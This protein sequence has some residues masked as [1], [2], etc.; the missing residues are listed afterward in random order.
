MKFGKYG[1]FTFTDILDAKQL[2][3]LPRRLEELGY[4][5]LWYPEA[6]NYE[7]FAV[8][9][10]LLSHSKNLIVGSGIANIYARDPAASVMG[11]NS[12]NSL[13][14]GRFVLGLGVSHAPIVSDLRGHDYTKPVATMRAYLDGMDQAWDG[15]GGAPKEKQV[16]L[17]ALGPNMSKLAA[18]RTLGSFPYNITPEQAGISRSNMSPSSAVICEQKICLCNDPVTARAAARAAL[19]IYMSLPNYYN[20]WFRLGF[21][22]DD[23]KDGGSDRLMD[24]MVFWGSAEQ[25][26]AKLQKY[27]D[28]SADQV[29]IQ[30]VRV[31]G[32]PGP[33]WD[34]LEA[35][36]PGA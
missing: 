34:A 24:A 8:G 14:G 17:A 1:V 21:N 6:T 4:S 35:L 11:H 30:P 29:V 3:E 27:F 32:K 28:G 33:C 23:L 20:N 25:I 26:K 22:E 9:G 19:G 7:A 18:E 31:D 2:A 12:L 15:L 16:V 5:T 10:Y 36:A 13:Y